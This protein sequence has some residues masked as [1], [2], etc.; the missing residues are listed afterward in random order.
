M[1]SGEEFWMIRYEHSRPST[2][3]FWK[4]FQTTGWNQNYQL[5][6]QEI[7]MLWIIV[8]LL[9]RYM[10]MEIWLDLAVWLLIKPFM[11]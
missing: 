4:L 7:N 2:E 5:T 9:F 10:K 6:R 1:Q 11:R 8:G 3:D